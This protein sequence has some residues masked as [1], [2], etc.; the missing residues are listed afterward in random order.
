MI[1]ILSPGRIKKLEIG[2]LRYI[3][4]TANNSMSSRLRILHPQCWKKWRL[5]SNRRVCLQLQNLQKVKCIIWGE[6]NSFGAKRF[7]SSELCYTMEIKSW[8]RSPALQ[9]PQKNS[10]CSAITI[11]SFNVYL[12]DAKGSDNIGAF[13]AY[14]NVEAGMRSK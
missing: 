1:M 12:D 11:T 7:A 9:G 3:L 13:S 10:Y 5:G 14:L 6:A 2:I 8:M 4:K